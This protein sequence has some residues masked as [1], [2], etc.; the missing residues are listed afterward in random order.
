MFCTQ[1]GSELGD[2]ARFCSQCA[3]PTELGSATPLPRKRLMRD[4]QNRK[5]AG[6][7]AGVAEYLDVDVTLMR[8]LWA[9]LTLTAGIGVIAYIVGWI[10]MPVAPLALPSGSYVRQP[11]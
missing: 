2:K 8:I 6:V 9:A 10:V 3:H 7:C 4:K 5:I 11:V 1:C